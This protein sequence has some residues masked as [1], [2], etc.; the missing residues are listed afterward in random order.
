MKKFNSHKWRTQLLGLVQ[1]PGTCTSCAF[2]K[3]FAMGAQIIQW[4]CG[5]LR[6]SRSNC[7]K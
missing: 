3:R 4:V 2:T 7:A 5:Q 6:A 1:Q